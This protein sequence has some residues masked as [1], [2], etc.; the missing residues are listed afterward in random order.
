MLNSEQ[1]E[2]T[3]RELV[4][5]VH[6]RRKSRMLGRVVLGKA[7]G[8]QEAVSSLFPSGSSF[9]WPRY[10]GDVGWVSGGPGV[11]LCA[12]TIPLGLL[13]PRVCR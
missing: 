4:L 5:V 1:W 6:P 12:L 7:F 11:C 10:P 8:G 9:F 13:F 2:G 3:A